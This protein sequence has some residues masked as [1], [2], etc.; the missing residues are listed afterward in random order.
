MSRVMVIFRSEEIQFRMQK[1][2][3]HY[4]QN[5]KTRYVFNFS[6]ELFQYNGIRNL[7]KV[8]KAEHS[9]GCR[10]LFQTIDS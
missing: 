6:H 2:E 10:L 4:K 5:Q 9:F 3:C 8:R 7:I 1:Q